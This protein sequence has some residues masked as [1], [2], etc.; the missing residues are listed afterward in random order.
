MRSLHLRQHSKNANWER[1]ERARLKRKGN[2]IF[3]NILIP[4]NNRGSYTRYRRKEAF[5]PV[6]YPYQSHDRCF[7]ANK[8]TFNIRHGWFTVCTVICQIT[9]LFHVFPE[10]SECDLMCMSSYLCV[11]AWVCCYMVINVVDK[12][13]CH[14]WAWAK[15]WKLNDKLKRL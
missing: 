14:S 13:V 7:F 4:I 12:R 8:N 6:T 10:Q 15:S 9:T 1:Y 2:A 5:V 11:I 3:I